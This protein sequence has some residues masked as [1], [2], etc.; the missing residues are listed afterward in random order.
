MGTIDMKDFIHDIRTDRERE[1]AEYR[2]KGYIVSSEYLCL[3]K[4]NVKC[5]NIEYSYGVQVDKNEIRFFLTNNNANLYLSIYEIYD[6]LRNLPAKRRAVFKKAFAEHLLGN[7]NEECNLIYKNIS[8]EIS[9]CI[10]FP[11][12]KMYLET[13]ASEVDCAQF[14]YLIHLIQ[15]KSNSMFERSKDKRKKKNIN[16]IYRLYGA[17]LRKR[18]ASAELYEKGW[19]WDSVQNKFVLDSEQKGRDVDKWI[20]KYYLTDEEYRSILGTKKS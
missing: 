3:S 7:V 12:G 13:V 2:R 10:V 20:E 19:V 11:K 8:Y 4:V 16:G 5:N 18:S 1:K 14:Y 15:S 17:L 9:P 6:I